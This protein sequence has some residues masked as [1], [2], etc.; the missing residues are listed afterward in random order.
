MKRSF[1]SGIFRMLQEVKLKL[2]VLNS[3]TVTLSFIL[4]TADLMETTHS[5]KTALS[6]YIGMRLYSR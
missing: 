6:R 5:P 3:P 4:L 2:Y 1:A